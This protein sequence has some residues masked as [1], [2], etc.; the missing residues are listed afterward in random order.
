MNDKSITLLSEMEDKLEFLVK[1]Q[2]NS[3]NKLEVIGN[4]LRKGFVGL[5]LRNEELHQLNKKL[6]Y[7]LTEVHEELNIMKKERLDK[8]ARREKLKKQKRL[9]KRDPVTLEIYNLLIK[10][11]EGP[12]YIS[13]RT[14][15]AICLLAV[16]G[17]RVSE[18]L[19]LKVG[20]LKTLLEE[21]WISIDRLK[22]GPSNHKAFLS[23]EGKKLV[24]ARERDFKFLFLLKDN[25]SY[26]FTSEQKL[27]RPLTRQTLTI[28]INKV[29]RSVSKQL[30]SKPKITSH[31]FRI[32]YISALWRNTEDIEFV[33][34]TIGHQNL[35]STSN[36]VAPIGDEERQNRILSI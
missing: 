14:R 30:Q 6:N 4:D 13:T 35:N 28:S 22:R 12:S 2:K 20:Q 29:M 31:S 21:G 3:S 33:R 18:L 36:Y 26:I 32:G 5:A 7:Q 25:D 17:I 11:S 10:K 16:T 23:S 34:Q 27:R 24:K 9:P 19:P 1:G 15:V 8:A